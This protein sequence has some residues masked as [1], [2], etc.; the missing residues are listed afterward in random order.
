MD[1]YNIEKIDKLYNMV[2]TLKNKN[3]CESNVNM[4]EFYKSFNKLKIYIEK[5]LVKES[6][7]DLSDNNY[8]KLLER[9]FSFIKNTQIEKSYKSI[10]FKICL[11]RECISQEICF[12]CEADN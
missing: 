9:V 7:K 1:T 3:S 11:I 4:D 2:T 6:L 8:K 10:F 5:E 12:L